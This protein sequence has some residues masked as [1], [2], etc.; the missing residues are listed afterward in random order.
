MRIP[1]LLAAAVLAGIAAPGTG[2]AKGQCSG[3]QVFQTA[4]R[5]RATYIDVL[6][7]DRQWV[8]VQEGQQICFSP[9]DTV[10]EWKCRGYTEATR[11]R[12]L[13]SKQPPDVRVEIRGG[14]VFWTCYER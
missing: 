14:E 1:I 6:T 10:W 3:K 7:G 11:C 8:S 4:D 13:R 5:C 12:R 2:Y 9:A